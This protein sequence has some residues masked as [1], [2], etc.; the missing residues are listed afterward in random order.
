ML[1]KSER[2][3]DLSFLEKLQTQQTLQIKQLPSADK[4]GIQN[5]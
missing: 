4:M 3:R 2:D 5:V 1:T